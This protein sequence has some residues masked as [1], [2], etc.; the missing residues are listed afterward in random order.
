MIPAFD[1]RGVLPPG[2]HFATWN[3]IVNRYATNDH[4]R[5]L[6]DGLIAALRSLRDAGCTT[7]Y[8]D[9]SFVTAKEL[10]GDFRAGRA[11][12]RLRYG[13]ELFPA[14]VAADLYGRTFLDYFQSHRK[15]GGAKGI[16]A[17][18]LAGIS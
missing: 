4:R 16:V 3:E 13:G 15:D 12:Q 9:G 17:I 7:A 11:A 14:N 2:V 5:F 10:P 18:D 1:W 8:L 6:I